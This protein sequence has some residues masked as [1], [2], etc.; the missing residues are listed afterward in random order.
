MDYNLGGREVQ[1]GL[2]KA[3]AAEHNGTALDPGEEE[4]APAPAVREYLLR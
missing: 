2:Q 3:E 4:E 1:A